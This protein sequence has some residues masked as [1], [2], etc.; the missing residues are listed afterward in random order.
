M[1]LKIGEKIKNLRKEQDV[2]Q[3]KLA[4]YLNISYQAISKWENGTAYPD[5]TLVPGIA[6]FFGVSTDELLCMKDF[7]ENEELEEYENLYAEN[8]KFG[9][10][11]ENINLCRKVLEKY[12][13]NYDWMLNLAYAMIEYNDTDE[14]IKYSKDH[15]FIDEAIKLCERIL[16]DCTVDSTR[17][18][19]IQILCLNYP[20]IGKK[21]LAIK[22][23]NE[24]PS[25]YISRDFLFEHIYEGEE[26]VK[27]CQSN[28]ISF[29]DSMANNIIYLTG[30]GLLGGELTIYEKIKF[31]E[32]ANMIYNIILGED[33][34][35]LFYCCRLCNNYTR[36]AKWWCDIGDKEKAM[37][38]LLHA[39]KNAVAYD[40]YSKQN[41]QHYKSII[42]NRCTS[43]PKGTSK[44]WK[45]TESQAL[46][47]KLQRESVSILRDMDEFKALQERLKSVT[48]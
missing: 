43:D 8:G 41:E 44:N 29:M 48:M 5:I 27:Q 9:K 34:N 24:M 45:G 6:N 20:K 7:A 12:P 11:F 14:H 39:E 18:G 31:V 25:M 23:A 1:M 37:D 4:D 38:C 36:L 16:E 2:T 33:E 26:Q 28:I 46:L 30:Y 35:S 21:D 15:K 19:A 32:A 10:V 40:E 17:H 47:N 13:R 3:E 22:L 42:V